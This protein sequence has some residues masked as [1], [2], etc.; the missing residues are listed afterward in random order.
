[1][2]GLGEPDFQGNHQLVSFPSSNGLSCSG[3]IQHTSPISPG[4]FVPQTT[5]RST[6]IPGLQC[7]VTRERSVRVHHIAE[8]PTLSIDICPPLARIR[9][10]RI[11]E[12]ARPSGIARMSLHLSRS[13]IS[14]SGLFLDG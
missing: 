5:Q 13:G 4:L 1:M 7:S 9:M 10:P 8:V 3:C 12:S 11:T 6:Q 2:A 14:V